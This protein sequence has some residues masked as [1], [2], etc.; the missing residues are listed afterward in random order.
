MARTLAPLNALPLSIS[1]FSLSSSSEL[2]TGSFFSRVLFVAV[3]SVVFA[4]V[5]APPPEQNILTS[6]VRRRTKPAKPLF[7]QRGS[8]SLATVFGSS[9]A[10]SRLRS[11]DSSNAPL[12]Q[13]KAKLTSASNWHCFSGTLIKSS[14]PFSKRATSFSSS[15]SA[16]ACVMV[17][18]GVTCGPVL[19]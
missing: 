12:P 2:G 17:L 16:S 9:P 18:P 1:D 13:L 14:T 6:A 15:A 19:P 5:A 10:F 11:V 3:R 8:S 4:A 7:V